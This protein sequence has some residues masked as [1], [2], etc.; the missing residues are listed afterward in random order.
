M[1]AEGAEARY[2]SLPDG[3]FLAYRAEAGAVPTVVFLGG[4]TSDMTGTKAVALG[5]HCRRR[6]RGYVR[7]DY[8]GHGASAGRFADATIGRWVEDAVAVID[9]VT[10]GPVV[11]VG[12]S[13][14]GWLMVRAALARPDR[15]AGLV[16][17]AAAPDFTVELIEPALDAET[18][19]R[20]AEEGVAFL[21]NP[22]GPQPTPV[23][24]AFLEE[25]RRHRVLGGPIPLGCPVRLLHGLEDREVPWRLSL[26]LAEA[27]E[28][29]DVTLTL[30]KGGD[31]RLSEPEHLVRLFAAVDDVSGD[32]DFDD[33][34]GKG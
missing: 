2:L 18:R 20:L 24:S 28:S 29:D 34:G 33:D 16:G 8:F 3:S 15:V 30:V 23:T 7:F 25:A 27:L 31:H 17:V 5:Q 26:R 22:Y 10:H 19:Q 9:R 14:G 1:S 4:F 32:W 12:S 6:G 13:M 11:L 21:P